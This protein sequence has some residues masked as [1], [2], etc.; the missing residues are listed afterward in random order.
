VKVAATVQVGSLDDVMIRQVRADDGPAFRA[1]RLEAIADSPTAFG[2]SLAETQSRPPQY[3]EQRVAS[4][5]AGHDNVL[6]VAESAA[7]WVGIAGGYADANAAGSV[8]LISMWVNPAFRGQG[9]GKRLVGQVVAWAHQHGAN[10]VA[11]WVTEGNASA[12]TL[13]AGCGFKE[14]G[15]L[16]MLP[17]HPELSE[18]RMVLKLT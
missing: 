16:Q 10:Q 2:S 1:I 14:T 9:I 15:E 7:G 8:D 5:A 12:C 4:A 17:S 11:L 18:K 3:W 6:F 13:Y